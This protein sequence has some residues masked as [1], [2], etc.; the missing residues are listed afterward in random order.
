[1]VI[2]PEHL[3][4]FSAQSLRILLESCGFEVLERAT[5]GKRFTV[6]YVAQ[7]LSHVVKPLKEIALRIAGT[8]LGR[9]NVSI[10]LYDNVFLLARRKS[11]AA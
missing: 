11:G 6:Q 4:L 10:N 1:M 8:R 5:L 7:T 9:A 2:P 3:N